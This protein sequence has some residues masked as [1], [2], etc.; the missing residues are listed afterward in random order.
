MIPHECRKYPRRGLSRSAST[1]QNELICVVPSRGRPTMTSHPARGAFDPIPSTRAP[2]KVSVVTD[3]PPVA[4]AAA[5]AV[6]IAADAKPPHELGMD[7]DQLAVAGFRA[8]PG[9]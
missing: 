2:A 5:L 8:E 4:D 3:L 6:P 9:Q 7:A 1:D